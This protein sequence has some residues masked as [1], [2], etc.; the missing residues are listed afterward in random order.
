MEF[1]LA[2]LSMVLGAWLGAYFGHRYSVQLAHQQKAEQDVANADA[3]LRYLLE[4]FKY[5]R[6]LLV[7]LEP[8]LKGPALR[9]LWS[10]AAAH[11]SHLQLDGWGTLVRAGVLP[12]LAGE[13]RNHL[14][15]ADRLTRLAS[16]VIQTYEARWA[17]NWDWDEHDRR[18][19]SPQQLN[20]PE[21]VKDDWLRDAKTITEQ[22]VT[23]IDQAIVTI[24]AMLEELAQRKNSK[25]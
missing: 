17:R 18:T 10:P 6:G 22:A 4:Q 16:Q 3:S 23:Q 12:L 19:H 21:L 5:N 14:S 7:I 2:G 25:R 9:N 1:L 20:A 11:A 13:Q 24:P 15:E 8:Y